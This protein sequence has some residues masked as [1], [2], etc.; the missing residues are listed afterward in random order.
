MERTN[1]LGEPINRK[2]WI[3]YLDLVVMSDSDHLYEPI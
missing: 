2:S 3:N 1:S